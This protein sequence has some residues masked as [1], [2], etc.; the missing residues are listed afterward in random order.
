MLTAA[1]RDL[2]RCYPQQFLTDVRTVC[3][4]L[5]EH[6]PY[7]TPLRDSDRAAERID[8][9]YP[10]INQCDRTPYHCLHG[11][12]EFLNQRLSLSIQPTVFKGDIHLSEQEKAWYSQVHEL[13]GEATPFWIIDAGGKYDLTIKWWQAARYQAVVDHFR[14]RIQFVQVGQQG[15]YHP[16]LEGVIDLRGQT[17]L[18]QLVRLVYHAQGVLCPVTSLMHLAAALPTPPGRPAIRPCVVVAGGREPAHWEAYPGHQFLHTNLALPCCANGGCWRDR[19]VRLRDGDPR[20]RSDR[21]CVNVIES[22]PRCMDLITPEEVIRRIKLYFEGGMLQYLTARQARRA[23]RAIKATRRNTFDQQPLNLH[24]AGMAC[25]TFVS[26]IPPYPNTFEG[27]GIVICGGGLKYFTCAWV[28]IHLLRRWGCDLPIELWHLGNGELSQPMADLVR[29]LGV[30]CIDASRLRRKFPARILHG[31]PL[32][33]YAILHSRFREVLLLDAD[34]VPV[35][36]PVYLFDAP[37]F[38]KTGAIFWPDYKFAGGKK[39]RAIWRSCG[40]RAPRGREFETGQ[41]LVD[42]QRCWAALC[43]SMWF[44][45]HA[46]FYY[47]H[48]HGDKE[49]FHLAFRKLKQR[50]WLV[51]TPIRRLT[52]TMCQ[53]DLEGRRLFQHR[54]MDKW[55][56]FLHN[57]RIKDFWFESE[58]RRLILRL[59]S[60]WD[61]TIDPRA[62][63]RFRFAANG[64]STRR[65]LK[66]CPIMISCPQR[67]ELRQRTLENL[68]DTDWGDVAVTLHLDQ[69]NGKNYRYRQTQCAYNALK[70]TLRREFDYL[71]FLEDDLEFNRHI[72]H[73]LERWPALR[74][75][76]VAVASLYNPSVNEF[77]CD[78]K[79]NARLVD[80]ACVFGSQAFLISKPALQYTVSHW[81]TVKGMQDIRISRLAR[82]MGRPFFYH[83]PS[84][85]QHTGRRSTWGGGFHRAVDFDANWRA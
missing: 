65:A 9:S 46:D 49:T 56:L 69:G 83:A 77:Q 63:R 3:P 12:I 6:N 54:N 78:A 75:G 58:C 17:S 37:Q 53:H 38:Q 60:L 32:K 66:L 24:S 61:G 23:A 85:V 21:R 81:H 55:N 64:A 20:D 57:R 36:N 7:V 52:A 50:Y 28:C 44:N 43:L 68:A 8:C 74:S 26:R 41:I 76:Q 13:T 16:K 27:R 30:E 51:K 15:H 79:L 33:P 62:A 73:N 4:D 40:L 84:L 1:V 48:V 11:F 39:A 59:R 70:E 25:D 82:R 35:R 71:L 29:P 80:P 19:I 5:W 22:L 67:L 31:W 2:H 72:R 42:K 10:L 47:Q 18:R 14:G 45:E 34:N